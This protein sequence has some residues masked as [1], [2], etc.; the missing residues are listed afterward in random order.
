MRV[1][2]CS[3]SQEQFH[4]GKFS[5]ESGR[6]QSREAVV[7]CLIGVS[8]IVQEQPDEV[9]LMVVAARMDQRRLSLAVGR[10]HIGMFGKEFFHGLSPASERRP[11][12]RSGVICGL[13]VYFRPVGQEVL[14]HLDPAILCRPVQWGCTVVPLVYRGRIRPEYGLQPTDIS[15]RCGPTNSCLGLIGPLPRLCLHRKNR[16]QR[17]SKNEGDSSC[18]QREGRKGRARKSAIHNRVDLG[19]FDQ[20]LVSRT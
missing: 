17:Q 2:V 6:L 19:L 16:Q 8:A 10:V 13:G 1:Y 12:E 20:R 11:V 9:S 18:A 15:P 4:D 5:A 7:V 14:N 3:V